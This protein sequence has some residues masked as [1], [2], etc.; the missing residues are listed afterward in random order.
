[1][2]G[3]ATF[4]HWSGSRRLQ[5]VDFT[6]KGSVFVVK[7]LAFRRKA[8]GGGAN[9]TART[10]D[11][12]VL[13]GLRSGSYQSDVLDDNILPGTAA[14]VFTK[15]SVSFPDWTAPVAPPAPFDFKLVYDTPFPYLGQKAF[16]WSVTYDNNTSQTGLCTTDRQYVAAGPATLNGVGLGPG[17]TS[18]GQTA[19][20]AHSF[21]AANF[22]TRAGWP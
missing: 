21:T 1:M 6:H 11:A 9:A 5:A 22:G 8:S 20:F 19:Q 10:F 18:T 12:S 13:M 7:S 17:C 15:K 4:T 3:N 14:T 16:V 2:E